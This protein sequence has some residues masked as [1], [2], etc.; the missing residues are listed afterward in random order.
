[1]LVDVVSMISAYD[2][3]HETNN[4]DTSKLPIDPVQ[5]A[6]HYG[7]QVLLAS[8]AQWDCAID[9]H[10]EPVIYVSDE[11]SYTRRRFAIAMMLGYYFEY[12]EKKNAFRYRFENDKF[13]IQKLVISNFAVNLLTD[14]F[15]IR[16]YYYA[17]PGQITNDYLATKFGVSSEFMKTRLK[18][19]YD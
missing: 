3:L 11:L 4:Y 17:A 18:M 15:L 2:V 5:I 6:H 16:A 7:I 12:G 13:D 1:M 19:I 8:K 9:L 14:K 10:N